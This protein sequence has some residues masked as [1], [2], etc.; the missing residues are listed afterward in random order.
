[1]S[2][3][4]PCLYIVLAWTSAPVLEDTPADG[5]RPPAPKVDRDSR[6]VKKAVK[7]FVRVVTAIDALPELSRTK[8]EEVLGVSLGPSRGKG[9]GPREHEVAVRSG[10]FVL[11]RL[12]ESDP[13]AERKWQVL[14]IETR[15]ELGVNFRDFDEGFIGPSTGSNPYD[16]TY[17]HGF[18]RAGKRTLFAFKRDDR[19]FVGVYFHRG[20]AANEP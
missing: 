7:E 13:G 4:G 12:R 6:K 15:L 17:T 19:L 16:G 3:F 10:P 14:S 11:A 2:V 1:M 5:P 8:V 9:N 20:A 18:Q